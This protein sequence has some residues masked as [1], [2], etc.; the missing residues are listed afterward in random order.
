MTPR[1]HFLCNL[2][3]KMD[4]EGKIYFSGELGNSRLLLFPD[5]QDLKFYLGGQIVVDGW[6]KN[7]SRIT[8]GEQ[9]T[10]PLA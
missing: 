9:S 6:R 5:D 3:K 1:L 7:L 10:T 4:A 2:K 8:P